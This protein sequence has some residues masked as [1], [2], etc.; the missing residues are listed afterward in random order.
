MKKLLIVSA[1]FIASFAH[2]D[3]NTLA[4]FRRQI[5]VKFEFPGGT[6]KETTLTVNRCHEIFKKK[7]LP[8]GVWVDDYK[9]DWWVFAALQDLNLPFKAET[10]GKTGGPW[11]TTI[12]QIG[13]YPSGPQGTW[14]YYINGIKSPYHISTQEDSGLMSIK[15]VYKASK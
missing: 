14:I 15:F 8:K 9:I 5:N 13:E 7:P 4:D 2:A 11:K 6:V 10:T 12:L 1:I 3:H